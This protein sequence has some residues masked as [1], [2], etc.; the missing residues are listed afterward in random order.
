MRPWN[1]LK[2]IAVLLGTLFVGVCTTMNG[3]GKA[4]TRSP[5]PLARRFRAHL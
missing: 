1:A 2:N 5:V 4:R 3:V